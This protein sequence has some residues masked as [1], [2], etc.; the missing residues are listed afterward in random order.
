VT[1]SLFASGRRAPTRWWRRGSVVLIVLTLVVALGWALLIG[2][3]WVYAWFQLGGLDLRATDP[4]A[5]TLGSVGA[6]APADATTVLVA[7]TGSRDPTIPREPELIAPVALVQFGAGRELPAVLL[8]PTDLVVSVDGL[9]QATLDEV[10]DEGGEDLL[11]RAVID[12]AEVRVDHVVS[13]TEDALPELVEVLG[14]VEICTPTGCTPASPQQI[15]TAQRSGDDEI[16]IS[17]L[18]DVVRGIGRAMDTGS[19]VRS[20]LTAKR[21]VDVVADEVRTDVSLRGRTLLSFAEALGSVTA[22]EHDRLPL[23]RNP[24][25]GEI[26]PLEEPIMVRFQHLRE[27]TPL[28]ASDDEPEDLEGL[29]IDQVEVAVLNGAGVAGLAGDVQVQLEAEGFR[30]IGTGNAASFGRPTTI[31]AYGPEPET[32][33]AAAV[34]LAERLGDGVQLD[35]RDQ[36]PTFEGQP[37]DVLVTVGTDLAPEDSDQ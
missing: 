37:V 20:P 4:D 19:V 29:V 25:T 11:A 24:E 12:Y 2:A 34:I 15:R 22:V 14:D 28:L 16:L 5:A 26:V 6:E 8:L 10:H 9:G 18:T 35:R 21:A 32:V 17:T 1:D 30:V 7:L 36:A 13:L 23:L 27:G 33:E 3:L 31:V